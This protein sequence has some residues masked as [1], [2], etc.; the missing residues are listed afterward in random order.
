MNSTTPD[1]RLPVAARPLPRLVQGVLLVLG[2]FFVGWLLLT[3]Y[4]YTI[5]IPIEDDFSL[6]LDRWMLIERA[7]S[8]AE[9]FR[10]LYWQNGATEHRMTLG[11]LLAKGMQVLTGQMNFSAMTWIGVLAV[12]GLFWEYARLAV[13]GLGLG[14]SSVFPLVALLLSPLFIHRYF[15][16][17]GTSMQYMLTILLGFWAMRFL[18]QAS[19][20]AFVLACICTVLAPFSHTH[21][22]FV[23]WAG[24]A[25]L[26]WQRRFRAAGVYAFVVLG[27]HALYFLGYE[28]DFTPR[29]FMGVGVYLERFLMACGSFFHFNVAEKA[30][31]FGGVSRLVGAL[32][33]VGFLVFA[34][35][36]LGQGPLPRTDTDFRSRAR[37]TLL[38]MGGWL[39]L[40]LAAIGVSRAV[41]DPDYFYSNR[42]FT[43]SI[44][45]AAAAYLA[46]LTVV[47]ASGRN[48]LV[49][50]LSLILTGHWFWHRYQSVYDIER[51]Y[52]RQV[53]GVYHF[54]QFQRWEVYPG[55]DPQWEANIDSTTRLALRR[56]WYELPATP[57][58]ACGQSLLA[59]PPGGTPVAVAVASQGT[60]IRLANQ[61][62]ALD[63]AEHVFIRLSSAQRRY[64]L[65]VGRQ[66]GGVRRYLTAG[67]RYA[68]QGF[69]LDLLPQRFAPGEYHVEVVRLNAAGCEVLPTAARLRLGTMTR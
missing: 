62:L 11:I 16:W 47:P 42:Y 9:K 48:G 57:L 25:V 45:F 26:L 27:V 54:R 39:L 61:T 7:D 23:G 53:A 67:K 43:V 32:A 20:W 41:A 12:L 18:P 55:E 64:L 46:V 66:P 49:L 29:E 30:P 59:P 28:S 38:G 35:R 1:R 22:L 4:R 33:V 14:W 31:R 19:R 44:P 13:R 50:G 40:A 58:D 15:L 8:W 6:Y 34:G 52:H 3:T 10:I 69:L 5:N 17:P 63:E 2:I 65:P 24:T 37:L 68:P 51:T 56:G 36:F 21:G 60:S